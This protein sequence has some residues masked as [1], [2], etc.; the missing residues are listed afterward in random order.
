MICPKAIKAVPDFY[1]QYF[2]ADVRRL[3]YGT[4]FII[5]SL[6]DYHSFVNY[7]IWKIKNSN[8]C[9]AD[10][11]Y[12]SVTSHKML[13]NFNINCFLHLLTCLNERRCCLRDANSLR[14]C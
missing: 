5:T 14:K 4:Y 7:A 13:I 12:F 10:R 6:Y 9:D 1:I 8:V 11:A 3:T 2:L